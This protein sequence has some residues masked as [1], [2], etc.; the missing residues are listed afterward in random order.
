[1][2]KSKK[3]KLYG[4]LILLVVLATGIVAVI[5]IFRQPAGENLPAVIRDHSLNQKPPVRHVIPVEVEKKIT[6]EMLEE[7]LHDLGVLITGEYSFTE[8][9]SYSSVLKD[10]LFHLEMKPT[11]SGY[12]AS[13]DGSVTA[14][15]DF[16]E[17]RVAKNDEMNIITVSLPAAVIRTVDI[18][19]ESFELFSEKAGMFN[20]I[21]VADFNDSLVELEN[22]ARTKALEKGLLIRADANARLM[23]NN[24]V[25]SLVEPGR[26]TLNIETP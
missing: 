8:V 19:P 7:G 16:S 26:Y 2:W 22:N 17:I 9:V 1:M 3:E 10:P 21:S 15:I 11:Q 13:Y 6:A 25:R 4:F 5:G 20:P 23:V 12:I 18:D 14:G 24:F